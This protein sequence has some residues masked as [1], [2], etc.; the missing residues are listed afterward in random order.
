MKQ[1]V[2]ILNNNFNIARIDEILNKGDLTD[3]VELIQILIEN[4]NGEV[5]LKMDELFAKVNM[6]DDEFYAKDQYL[7]THHLISALRQYAPH[8]KNKPTSH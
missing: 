1:S 4:P 2:R 3:F 8:F 5:A 7:A 6:A